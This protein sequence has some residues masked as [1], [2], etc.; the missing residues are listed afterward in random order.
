MSNGASTLEALERYLDI[1]GEIE[2]RQRD[3]LALHGLMT[4]SGHAL[5]SA[6][7]KVL[8]DHWTTSDHGALQNNNGIF[9]SLWVNESSIKQNIGRYNLHAIKLRELP[10]YRIAARDFAETFRARAKPFIS[11]WPSLRTDFGPLTLFEGHFPLRS[12]GFSSDCEKLI[13][14][15]VAVAPIIDQML[16]ERRIR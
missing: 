1:F 11:Q 14:D 10:G 5:D 2:S 15:F 6:V 9:F 12:K 3:R 8:K 7:L 4:K 13:D 16:A